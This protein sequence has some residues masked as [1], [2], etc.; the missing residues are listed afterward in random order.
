[1]SRNEKKKKRSIKINT[2]ISNRN[3]R[4]KLKNNFLGKIIKEKV[5][6]NTN[7]NFFKNDNYC[8][9]N[10]SSNINNTISN[11]SSINKSNFFNNMNN[12]INNR[13]ISMDIN[14]NQKNEINTTN[15]NKV[16]YKKIIVIKNYQFL[17]ITKLK[18]ID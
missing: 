7:N 9:N 8:S 10:Q 6:E 16:N 2:I 5:G 18:I 12:N 17:L 1:M 11:I 3:K 14:F 15:R 4:L 13:G